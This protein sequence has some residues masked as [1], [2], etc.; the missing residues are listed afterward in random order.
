MKN[1]HMVRLQQ[2]KAAHLHDTTGQVKYYLR[3][4]PE[5]YGAE[6]PWREVTPKEYFA[7]IHA[8]YFGGIV[9]LRTTLDYYHDGRVRDILL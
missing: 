4:N 3:L 8:D 2:A 9:E 5:I 6:K 1:E 7:V